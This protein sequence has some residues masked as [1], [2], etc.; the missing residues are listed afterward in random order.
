MRSLIPLCASIFLLTNDSIVADIVA[1]PCNVYTSLDRPWRATNEVGRYICDESFTW[2]GWYRLFYN[3]LNIRMP[4]TC[5]SGGSC[6]TEVSLWL[7]GSHP[8]VED[9]VVTRQVCGSTWYSCCEDRFSPI[10]IKA[11]PGDYFVYE[12]LKPENTCSA[13]C[14]ADIPYDPC[15]NYNI[16]DDYWR[17]T[18]NYWNQYG[19]IN[20]HDDA[21][22]EWNGWYRLFI[23]GSSAQMPEWCFSS[24]ACGG[25][26]SLWIFGSHP[27]LSDGVVTR[28]VYGSVN[29]QCSSYLSNPIQVKACPGNFYVYKLERPK[30]SIPGPVYCAVPFS[31]PDTDPC[32]TYKSL[33]DTWRSTDNYSPSYTCDYNTDWNGWYRLFYNGQS[34]EMPDSC[35]NSG[36]CG[37]YQPLWLDGA[38]PQVEDGVITR[39]VCSPT[40][41]DCCG[42]RSHPIQVKACPGNYYVYEF[43]QPLLCSSYCA[44][45]FD[46]ISADPCDNYESLDRPW[47]A[48][49]ES[50]FWMCT[51]SFTWNGWYRL[52]YNGMN[53]QMPESCVNDG[54]CNTYNGLSLSGPHPQLKDGVVTMEVCG[55]T[56]YG[57][58]GFKLKPIRVK[59]CPGDYYVY[60]LIS[61]PQVCSGYCIDVNTISLLPTTIPA[62]IPE[63]TSPL[64]FDPCYTYTSLDNYW[65]DNGNNYG[66]DDSL[67]HWDGW[68]RLFINGSS[69]QMPEWCYTS[70]SCGGYVS[71]WLSGSHPQLEDGVVTRD[72]FGSVNGQC[73][74]YKSEPI[75]VKAC[76]GISFKI[77]D[78]DPCYSYTSLDEI[79][80]ATNNSYFNY[81]NCDYNTDWNGWYRL[82]YNGQSVEMPD[83]CVNSG[84]C[85]SYQPLWLD[86][87]HPQVEDGVVTRQVCSPTWNDCCG[88]RSH[89]IQV[90]ACPG[91]YYV[92][93]F[94]RPSFCSSYCADVV[95]LDIVQESTPASAIVITTTE[96]TTTSEVSTT[97]EILYDPCY[98][99]TVLD[100]YWRST[101]IQQ[102]SYI[103]CDM[104]VEWNGWYRLFIN[105]QSAQMPDTCVDE[106]KCSTHAPLWLNGQHP[107]IEDGVVTRDICGH[108][109]GNCCDFQSNPIRVKACPGNYYVYE[110]VK[111]NFCYGTYCAAP[112]PS[113]YPCIGYNILDQ[114]LRDV[115]QNPYQY[116]YQYPFQYPYLD[117]TRVEWSGWYRL[118]LN[119]A[120]AQLSEWCVSLT[121]CGGVTGLYL[122][123]SHPDPEDG[124]VTREVIGTFS[125]SYWWWGYWGWQNTQCGYY[126]ST[127]IQVKACEGNFYVYK[128]GS[129]DANIFRPSY[130]A[131]AFD[132]IS[133]DPCDNYQSFDR[134]WRATNESGYYIC[135]ENFS[136]NGWYRLF[137]NGMNIRMPESCVNGGGCYTYNGLSL[138]GP[139][140]QIEDGVVTME[141]CGSS[142]YGCCDL[143]STPIR[144]KACPGDYYVYEFVKP[145]SY[146]CSGYCA[147]SSTISENLYSTTMSPSLTGSSLM[148][149][150]DY[151]PCENYNRLDESWRNTQIYWNQYKLDDTL[152]EWDGWYRLFLNGLNAQMPEWCFTYMTCGGY[153]SLWLNGSHPRLEDGVV[154]REVYSSINYQCGFKSSGPI[155]V[156]AC[157]GNYYV[158]KFKRP[159]VSIPAPA[160]CAVLSPPPIL[161]PCDNYNS[162]DEPWRAT[163]HAFYDKYNYYGLMCD[164][165]VEWNGWYRLFYNGHSTKMPESCVGAYMCGTI[166]PLWLNSSHPQLE[167][168]VVTRK[169]CVPTGDQCCGMSSHP[170]RVKACP[171][172]YFVYEFVK[173]AFCSAYCTENIIIDR[174]SNISSGPFYPFGSNDTVTDRSDDGISPVIYFQQPF[175][176][177]G[178]TY[179][180]IYISNNGFL[181][182]DWPWYSYYPFQFPGY[183][184]QDLIAPFWTDLDNRN[185]GVV[186]YHQYTSGSVLTQATQDINQYF[187]DLSFS[188]TWVFVATWDRVPYYSNSD[189]YLDVSFQVVL[190]SDGHLSFI[191]MNYGT[192]APSPRFVEAGYDTISSRYYA[193]IRG[194]QQND[195]TNLEHSSNVNVPGRWAFRA[196]DG[197]RGCVFNGV[198]VQLDDSFWSD[199]TCQ[200]RCTCTIG[201][202]QCN[203]EPC[204]YSQ[205]CRPAAFQY[206]CQNIPRQTCTISGDPHYYTFDNQVF[207]FQGTCTYVLSEA[208]DSRVPYY[209]IEGKN[210]HRGS[211]YVAWTRMVRVFV[212]DEEIELV[213]DHLYE[214][215]V[216]GS[217]AATP[218]SLHNGSI[219]VYQSGFSLAISTNFG[220][221]VTYDAYS[222]VS[223][224]V[225]YDYQNATCGLCG[226]F[227][228]SPEDDFRSPSGELFSSDVDFANSWKAESD[229]DPECHNVRCT[230]LACAVCTT[231]Q[232][233]VYS[234][235]YH[236]GILG[237]VS[238]PFAACH[239]V[240]APQTY[241]ESCVYDLCL[242]EGYQP[243]LC[244]ALNVYAT[245]CQ[246]QGVH[247][248]QWRQ[249][250]FCEIQ[251]PEHSHFEPQGTGCPGTCSNPSAPMNCPL[252]NQESCI[253]DPGYILSAGSCVPQANCGCTFEGFYYSDGQSVVLDEDCGRRCVCSN[254]LMSCYEH[255]CSSA[256]MC[257]VHEGVRG[258]R[259]IGYATCSVED[260]GSYHTYDGK[261]FR[262][263]GACGLTLSKVMGPSPLPHF[264]LTVEKVP[265]GLQDFARFLKFEAG[266]TQVSIE[267]GEG[268]NVKVDGQMIGLP[269]SVN[270]GQIRIYH[271][272]VRGFVLETN[273]GVTVRADWPHIVRITAP[274]SYNGTLGGLCGNL[275]G[276]IADE[277]YSPDGVLLYDTQ[278]F[279]E[280]WRDGSLSVHC[281]ESFDNWE[282]GHYQNRS[283]FIDLCG[284]MNIPDGPFAECSRTLEPQQRITDCTELLEQTQGSREALCEAL[285]GYTLLCQQN[286]I[287]VGEW[288]S[289]TDCETS[290]P[291]NSHYAVCAT[292]CP[293]SC[294]SLS[295]PFQCSLQCQ[296]GCQCDDGYVLNGDHCDVVATTLGVIDNLAKGSGMAKS[297]S[298][299]VIVMELQE[300]Y[301]VA[302]HLAVQMRSVR[303][304]KGNMGAIISLKLVA[305]LQETPTTCLLMEH[306]LT[307]R[308]H[309]AIYSPLYVDARN[310][311][312]HGTTVAITVEVFVNVSGH[313]VHLSQSTSGQSAVEVDGERRNLPVLLDSGVSVYSSGQ[314]IY[315]STDFG[316]GVS[317]GGS[318]TLNIIVPTEYSGVT[319]GLCGN[320]NGERIDDFMTPSGELVRSADHFGASW[321]IEDGLA[322]NDGCGGNCPLCQDQT[323]ARSQCEIIRSSEGPFSFCHVSIAP[324]A[325]Y[326]DCVFDVCLSGNRNEV[327]CRSIQTYASACQSS[328]A[329]IYPWR[330]SASCGMVCPEDSHYELC[331]T[332]C[333]QTCASNIDLSCEHTCSEGCFCNEGLIRSGGQC[334]PVEY[335]GCTH[336]GFYFNVG[337]QFWNQ[338]CSQIC[339]CF[340]PNDFRCS[341]HA[342]PLNMECVVENGVRGCYEA[343]TT[344]ITTT[345]TQPSPYSEPSSMTTARPIPPDVFYPFGTYDTVNSRSDDGSS[346]VIYLLQQF[347]FF[348]QSYDQIYVNNNGDLTFEHAYAS[349]SPFQFPGYGITDII[350]PFW[351]DFDTRGN[352]VVSY[353]QYT[354]GSVLTQATQDINQ[355]F[356]GLSF[357][358]TW[359]FIATWDRVAYFPVT[360]TETSFQ[361]VLVS[362]G[363]FTFI[364]MNYGTIAPTSRSIQA[365]Y[366]TINSRYHFSIPGSFSSDITNLTYS[367]NVNVPGRWAFRTDHGSRGCQFNGAPVQLRDSFW[368]DATCQ[369]RCTCT[370]NGLQCNEEPCNYSQA[371]RPAAFQY[372]CQNIHRQ[373][374]TISGDPHY[375]TF[376]QQVFHFQGTCTYVLS[377]ACDRRVPYYRIEGKNEHRGSTYVAWTRMVRVFVY[378]EEIELVKDHLYEA[379]VNGSFA[380]TPFS[381][382]NG[383]IQVYQSG[384]SLVISTNFGLLVTYDAYSYV[385]ISVPYDYQ[386]ATCGLCG[387][388]NY[389]PEDDF[390]SPSGELFSSDVDFANSWKAESDTDPECHNVRCTG[391]A[392]AVCTTDQNNVYSDSY[393]CGI[394]GDVSGPFAACHSVLAPQTYVESCVY[395]LCLGEGYQP[396]LC[397][398]LN[399]YATQC[400]QQGVHLG[401]WRQQG[402][403]EIQCPEHSHFE[404][405]GTGCP[406]T[407]SNPSAPMN[408]PLPNQESCICDPGYI[409]SAG[410]CVPQA[411]CGCTFEGFYYSDGQSVVL[412]EDCGRRCVCSNMLMSCYQHQC[413]SAEMCDVHEGVRGCRPIGYATCSVEDLGSYH[414]YDGKS[415]RYPGACGLTLSK[416]MGPSPL[417]H[418]ML[419]VEKVPRGLQDFARFLKFEAGG[420]QVSIEMGEGSNVKVDGQMIGLPVSVNSGQIRIYHS[421]VRGFV[422][423]TN[424]G[425]TV[426]ADWPHIVRITAPSCYNGTLGGLC[427][428]LNGDIADEFYSP[429]GVLLY[430]NQLFAE[431]WRDGS[432][433]VHC[434]ESFDN[435]EPGHYQ[436][437]S[438]FIDLCGIM[439]IPDGP[440]AECSRTLDPQQR[441]TDCTELL[442]QTQGSREALCEALR[443]YT[444]LCQQNSIGVGEWR[445]LTDCE[446]S[447]PENS[448]Y[449][450]C[451][452][453]C[454]SSCPSLS[455]PF[456][457]SLQCQDGCQCD[458]GYVLNGDHCVL[459]TGCGCYYSGRYRQPGERFWHGEE[460]QFL[461][462]CNG[463]TGNV[464]CSPSSC[465]A[466]EICQVSEG[467]YGCH[468]LPQAR[469]SASGDPHYM[470]FD[471]TFFDF[472]GTCRYILA[473][474]CNDTLGLPYFQVDARNEAWH[475]TTV[476][477]TVEV[478]VN[479]SGHM[480]HMSQ[481][482]S[483]QS[484]VEVDGERRN[485][486]VHLDSGRVSVYSSGQ[487]IYVSTDFGF[488]VSYG[489]SW[490]LNIIVP[491]EYSGVTCGLCGNFNGERI[492]DFMTPSG[493]LVRSADHFGASWKIEDG[494]ACNDGCGG[495]CPLCQDQTTARSQC[496]IIRSSEGPFSFCHVSIA[497]QAYYD[498]CVF[499]VCLS[500]NRNEVLCRSI[501]TYASA[502]HS[503]NAVI[504][505]WR[506]SASCG[507]VCPEDSHYEL[508]GTDCGH[509]C[510]SNVDASCEHTCSEGCFC[511]DGLVRSGGQ[512]VPVE[513]CGCTHDGFYFNVAEQFLNEDCSQICEC[514]SLN[515][516]RCSAYFCPS[517]TECMISNGRRVCYEKNTIYETTT[518]ETFTTSTITTTPTTTASSPP[519]LCDDLQCTEDERCEEKHGVYGCSCRGNHHRSHHDSFDFTETC[520]S[521]YG[522]ISL[523]RCQLFDAGYPSNI[524][525]LNDENCKGTVRNGKVEF[526]FDNNDHNCGTSLLANGTHIIYEN[527]VKGEP[528]SVAHLISREKILKISFSC[529]YLQTQTLSMDINPLEST[530][531]KNL[532]AGQGSYRVRMIPYQDAAFSN[533]FTGVVAAEV[534]SRMYVEVR[535]DGVDGRQFAS[536][537]DSCWATPVN[538]PFDALRWDL[539]NGVSTFSRFS[540]E[541]FIFTANATKIYLHCGIH[542]CLLTNNNCPVQCDSE[543]HRREERSTENHDNAHISLGPFMWPENDKDNFTET[544]VSVLTEEIPTITSNVTHLKQTMLNITRTEK[545][546]HMEYS[547]FI[548]T[549]E[550]SYGFISLSRC[551]LFEAGF[552][553]D[554]LHLNDPNCRGTV[555]SGRVEFY[556]D[557]GDHI[558]GTTLLAN[559]TH[560]IYENNILGASGS[561]Q[562]ISRGKNLKIRFSCAYPRTQAS[563]MDFSSLESTAV[564]VFP[565]ARGSY[566]V[567]M[568]PYKDPSFLEPF[569]STVNPL[570][571]DQ[572]FIE[573]RVSGVDSHQFSSVI[574]SCWATPVN[575]PNY[576]FRWNLIVGMCPSTNDTTIILNGASTSSRF[577]FNMFVLISNSTNIYLHCMIHL[578]L[579][580]E[581][582]C[583]GQCDS[584]RSQGNTRSAKPF[585]NTTISLGPLIFYQINQGLGVAVGEQI[586]TQVQAASMASTLAASLMIS[587]LSLI[588]L[589]MVI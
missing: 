564:P 456:Q 422:L 217:F 27:K 358:A 305:L 1:D 413:S 328:Y 460:C 545:R 566:S 468:H 278:L 94:T 527:F 193:S 240:L 309:A 170:I 314:Y 223:I 35:V 525:H 340:A 589:L 247:L 9:G 100:D 504:Y 387:N 376:D 297:A 308:A 201:G 304:Q 99:Y 333:V 528:N 204:S 495:N 479:V 44:A 381:L 191:L 145:P 72:V 415:F 95:Q 214:A 2:N 570:L 78:T 142:W 461:C 378:D 414:T 248:G 447:C 403:C 307:S 392:C 119:G 207:H 582:N 127:S 364:L 90:K 181:T 432:L 131:V 318:W 543:A 123:G 483:G 337:E 187:S 282:P 264:M 434:E 96:A 176:Y 275:N 290:C 550:N 113:S 555:H 221:L 353:H 267:M 205:A 580:A 404:P 411:N 257:A 202:L 12:L 10:R 155:E 426:R 579:P 271:S 199:A 380:A 330:E 29:G 49:N 474:I 302:H 259:P 67:L 108:W 88:Y 368:S 41:N 535:V 261:S 20:A 562:I 386:N 425:V 138:S 326:D 76:P 377:E 339:E 329:V 343:S 83:S 66:Y 200:Q 563:S 552:P 285:R 511:N 198:P 396:I 279:A 486:P 236:C 194:S 256:E 112:T 237:D 265:R 429:D 132:S 498:D 344:S 322:C 172:N 445:S 523:S 208:C 87:A 349:F 558:C 210:E 356:P 25:Y 342:C 92:Y 469:C 107:Q 554:I 423:E 229:T 22:I 513:N 354:S 518:A 363:R 475:G 379:R 74:R 335:C 284:I 189:Y 277:F 157:P 103:R 298:F 26:T 334:V 186:S 42:Y 288:R 482:T 332:D 220:L 139:H 402:F 124:V 437:R 206:S 156:K 374:C 345:T 435:W 303:S 98:N 361:V 516:M 121:G 185:Y 540:F 496:E 71:L 394:L 128:L 70:M 219:Q 477:I 40:W 268:S 393:H 451:A 33:N 52:F 47:R 117:D 459:P 417:P 249:Q 111:P 436:N 166:N 225:P 161:D 509:T 491:T 195:V 522:L 101:N 116:L 250:G 140:P 73:N 230:G 246:Q 323:T 69:A 125:R 561:G 532:P 110:F 34:V 409:L 222:Y 168:G 531:I 24:M 455:F 431:S 355:Y 424:F 38:H 143:K 338:D 62:T 54:V 184:G 106:F 490:T 114:S 470:S 129:P 573:V 575:D 412:D 188:A 438:Q 494:L 466:E 371:C 63:Y 529:I 276:D 296:E 467:E 520:E 492:D 53:I 15:F 31:T 395:D 162:L 57:C 471:G 59:A 569:N 152:V 292:S 515:D 122:S 324:Q 549:C 503:S 446:T 173:P 384:F 547:D 508:C 311:A 560:F 130:C 312:W 126:R 512:C 150:S 478:F 507:M 441:I 352:G 263:P 336:D 567:V 19:H 32:Y 506:E 51:D 521:S 534:S 301:I 17:S 3:G 203:E 584:Q 536:V 190:I 171:G 232:S 68:Y 359:V 36:M 81:I 401:Q 80:R 389:S 484:A 489:G 388:F 75:Q 465:S 86:G 585:D 313:M 148:P 454:P 211:T 286:S 23:N 266:G 499:D 241:V 408:C 351:T 416:V 480:V 258:C 46:K 501:Q 165:N 175:V 578:C 133:D 283:Q 89:P 548:E 519:D 319:C 526:Y 196:D 350:A 458:D 400:Q 370:N 391:L 218:F 14:T 385:S 382:H 571:N 5:V 316:F 439:N 538:D 369:Q 93:E 177:F 510:A 245:Q 481:S 4:E 109:M 231:D 209:R 183:G 568:I 419:T 224:S 450:V 347:N 252:P 244:Q 473:T 212:Y 120:N 299:C 163:T 421:G 331:D 141:V 39:Q 134:P 362:G 427:G 135:D 488:G 410:S 18:L 16:V 169:V 300:M 530:V 28:D 399:V 505:P 463:V 546:T 586:P 542:L 243:I 375:Y 559:E 253:C 291:E 315:V 514:F 13:Y 8:Q 289:L 255:Q 524:L 281:E 452:T 82:F 348:G 21:S 147:D 294:P 61:Q 406:G 30:L 45:T 320:F 487:Y 50:E 254:M 407:C 293:S 588:Y 321:K 306:S 151:D 213:K 428:N 405:Q 576:S 565:A 310:E 58:C 556:F 444:L 418:F 115:R 360:G 216:N 462:D 500:G 234:D 287:G 197:R 493:E 37:S 357:S 56:G 317:Y 105:S 104:N 144:V 260:L 398:A 280:S 553:S 583:S 60:E 448:H 167:D 118:Y 485:L 577:S 443:G 453:S 149:I 239:S 557:D 159:S 227:N 544:M 574:D 327:L 146:T 238:G 551:Q 457:C 442:E 233:N 341:A 273:F 346:S 325:Y 433:S 226:N 97:L 192:I 502:C 43:V 430:D 79:W 65:R 64:D 48:T 587:L 390:R 77:P 476:A 85:G 440:F 366:D 272:G 372:S 6:N 397:Q 251:C 11:C 497:P 365:G 581:N 180:Q 517:N 367:S 154:T 541:M 182:F 137:Y 295:F 102:S 472:Q 55:S 572:L 464:H 153:S 449:A 158:Y 84:M 91:N 7:N 174:A 383:S 270:S 269:V 539:I 373:T 274:S 242:G 215:R 235:S 160:Y 533:P 420:N 262:Y 164:Y 136:W 537:I 178:N 179:N 228:Y